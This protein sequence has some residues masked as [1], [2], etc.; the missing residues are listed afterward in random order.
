MHQ[1]R[2]RQRPEA[3][4]GIL[5]GAGHPADVVADDGLHEALTVQQHRLGRR[6]HGAQVGALLGEVQ[7]RQ[8]ELDRALPVSD[9][10]VQLLH[11][12]RLSAGQPLQQRHPPQRPVLVEVG[13]ALAAGLLEDV[14]PRRA[15]RHAEAAHMK[16]QV[17]VGVHHDAGR[18]QAGRALHHL[19]AQHRGQPG[20]ALVAVGELVPVGALVEHQHAQDGGSHNRIVGGHPPGGEIPAAQSAGSGDGLP[21][22]QRLGRLLGRCFLGRGLLDGGRLLG[23]GFLRRRLLRR[24]LGGQSILGRRGPVLRAVRHVSSV[25]APGF[26]RGILSLTSRVDRGIGIRRD[27]GTAVM[28]GDDRLR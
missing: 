2:H 16:G 6:R 17:E 21:A 10:V 14:L 3:A 13:H 9:G 20:R 4:D 7:Q 12:H 25:V 1:R 23:R 27:G 24:G 28:R 18:F 26:D 5:G 19:R 8:P 11:Q 15:L 22:A